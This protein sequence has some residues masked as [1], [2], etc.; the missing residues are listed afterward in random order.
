MKW[1]RENPEAAATAA[2]VA[3]AA[4]QPKPEE[5]KP[6]EP[7]VKPE[8]PEGAAKP[9]VKPEDVTPELLS[10]WMKDN[11]ALEAALKGEKGEPQR[12]ALYAM[13][14]NNARAEGLLKIFP[15]TKAGEF[16]NKEAT[17]MVDIR[18]AFTQAADDPAQMPAAMDRFAE[19]FMD[20][21]ADGTFKKDAGGNPVFYPEYEMLTQGIVT[22]ALE[23]MIGDYTEMA[24]KAGDDPNNDADTAL[25]A[26]SYVKELIDKY[27]GK[28]SE[29][30]DVSKL[31]PEQ[32]QWQERE[33][34]RLEAERQRLGIASTKLTA[35]QKKANRDTWEKSCNTKIGALVG[36]TLKEFMAEQR[37]NGVFIPAYVTDVK[38][39]SG[40][41]VFATQVFDEFN[42]QVMSVPYFRDQLIAFQN[43]A[44]TVENET[45]R[46]NFYGQLVADFMPTIMD[47]RIADVQKTDE[48]DRKAKTGDVEARQRVA[49]EEPMG[50][51]TPVAGGPRG[52]TDEQAMDKAYA[53]VDAKY[54]YGSI[55]RSQRTEFAL[56]E[57]GNMATPNLR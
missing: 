24:K 46:I 37:K 15:N 54:P 35:D 52:M 39:K 8:E 44:P 6:T 16:A 33:E 19:Q 50:G 53:A 7:E 3:A 47:K 34:G 10:Q 2:E 30:P 12:R 55:T 21:N 20:R 36:R 27:L 41:S 28:T 29:A 31:T 49:R 43:A 48:A 5:V 51:S 26:L 22:G 14:R 4:E 56:N 45:N 38:D 23:D 57:F 13:A 11:P 17:K 25:S 32:R 18:G 42:E 9:A 40:R 1:E